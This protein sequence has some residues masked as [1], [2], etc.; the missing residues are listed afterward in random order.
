MESFDNFGHFAQKFNSFV[1]L[2]PI[3]AQVSLP[4]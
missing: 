4:G 1:I 3:L 2:H